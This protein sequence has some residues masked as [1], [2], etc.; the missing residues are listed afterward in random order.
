M[1]LWTATG[2]LAVPVLWLVMPLGGAAAVAVGALL[3]ALLGSLTVLV[4]NAASA[5]FLLACPNKRDRI[6]GSVAINLISGAG[7]GLAG[8]A[9]GPWLVARAAGMSPHFEAFG[10]APLDTYRLYFLMLLPLL[11]AALAAT[12]LMRIEKN[13]GAARY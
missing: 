9:I 13:D 5:H 1:L 6:A 4:Y 10:G 11:V 2:F 12:F 3:F 8:S 7:A